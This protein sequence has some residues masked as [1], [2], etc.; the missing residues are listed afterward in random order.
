M[1]RLK[2]I[3][4]CT[5][6]DL[7][8]IRAVSVPEASPKMMPKYTEKQIDDLLDY[9]KKDRPDYYKPIKFMYLVGRRVAETCGIT[10]DDISMEGLDPLSIQT[11]PITAKK[12]KQ[13]PPPIYLD[14]TELKTL[15]KSA[16]SNNKTPWLFPH[17]KGGKMPPNYLWKYLSK[18][19]LSII[20][21]KITSHFFRKRFLTIG[22]RGGLNKDSMAMANIK[23]IDVVMKHYIE[24]TA[25]GQAKVLEKIRGGAYNEK[26]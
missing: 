6:D 26:A 17:E 23:N 8:Q 13:I 10:K 1:T 19:S 9:I 20:G 18:T 11:R 2:D 25:G 14:D 7:K 21:I 4:E 24:T 3:G 15:I 16:L 22:N 12:K 5:E